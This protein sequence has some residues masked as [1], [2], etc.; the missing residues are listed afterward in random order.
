[1]KFCL[2][3]LFIML[4]SSAWATTYY[5]RVDGGTTTQC[6]GL[7]YA[8][9]DGSGTGEACAL[10]HPVWA[11][12][13]VGTTGIMSAGDTLIIGP[14]EYMVG[15]GMPNTSGC[16]PSFSYDCF[17]DDV[18]AGVDSSNKT[19]I[20][21]YG[22]DTGCTDKPQLWGTER[23]FYVLGH[24]S[25]VDIQCLDITDH[26]A[27]IESGP[28][29][30][31][32]GS[33]PVQCERTTA[34]FGT[35]AARGI[36]SNNSTNVS[37]TNVD[38]HGI[39]GKGLFAYRIGDWS[40]TDTRIIANG[41]VGWDSDGSG[42]DSYTG[43]V[44]LTR[45]K[46]EWN[47]C[48][49]VYPL[50]TSNLSSS[51][52]K[53]HCWSQDQGGF[54]DGIGLGDGAPGNWTFVDSSVSWNTSDGVDLLHGSGTG[55]VIF[56]RSKAEGNAGQAFKSSVGTTYIENSFLIGNCGFFSGQS[57]TS[58]KSNTGTPTGFNNCRAAGDTVAFAHLTAGQKLY[59]YNSTILSNG[60]VIFLSS[61][62]GCDGTSV[63]KVDNSIIRGG[64]EFN[65]GSDLSDLYYPSGSDGNG[66][67][68][69]GSLAIDMDNSILYGSKNAASDTDCTGGT[70]NSCNV[71]P[72][73]EG[74]ILQ[75]PASPGYYTNTNY[76]AQLTLA[77]GSPA[78]DDAS[79]AITCN[80]DCT[81]DF[82]NFTRGAS[83][84]IG[85]YEYGTLGGCNNGIQDGDE[86]DVDCGGS[87]VSCSGGG[88]G[89]SSSGAV[90]TNI[91]MSNAVLT[92]N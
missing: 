33:Y 4:S 38:I 52:D 56:Y 62:T 45:S 55:T 90:I 20:Y 67:G 88:G 74:T 87:C 49:E 58:T 86:T 1:M 35:W 22:W 34:P 10:I 76:V 7:A 73:F 83:W 71:D 23:V 82:N 43:T 81:V 2:F 68:P 65:D 60:N 84:D 54:G 13:G 6:T 48:G 29:D 19:K 89:G 78:R 40:L 57:F 69:C 37:Y 5:V 85:A 50:T 80:Q 15:L 21:G 30:G 77:S 9:Y 79:E 28:S 46:I 91:I 31:N 92:S 27:C 16:G 53:H 14:G 75:G 59:V 18:P 44:T 42:D 66:A 61:G 47:G 72:L 36:T 39:A 64:T 8:A 3:L 11:L 70:N 51:T 26:S 41:F 17:M 12:G 63:Y 24:G 32:Q 25:N